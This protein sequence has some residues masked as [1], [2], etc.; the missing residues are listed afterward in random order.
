MSFTQDHETHAIDALSMS[1]QTLQFYAFPPF[2]LILPML[3]KIKQEG[4]Q[5]V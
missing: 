1:W 5:G 3:Q 2:S 4:V